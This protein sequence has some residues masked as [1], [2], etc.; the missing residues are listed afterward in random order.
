MAR[1]GDFR[2]FKSVPV[3]DATAAKRLSSEKNADGDGAKQ[4]D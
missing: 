3:C 1:M 2:F 4:F